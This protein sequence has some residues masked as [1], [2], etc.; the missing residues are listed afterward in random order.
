MGAAGTAQGAAA[1]FL[2]SPSLTGST[3]A[4][5]LLAISIA[6]ARRRLYF[7]NAYFVAHA[8]LVELL[9][10]AA[11]RGV[12]VRVLTNG[13]RSDVA[14]TWLAGR[15]RY[16]TLLAAGVRIYEY[17]P[18]TLHSKTFV[19]TASGPLSAQPTSIIARSP[20]TSKSH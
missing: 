10:S 19:Q 7:T 2:Y 15:S 11:R 8:D 12:D 5:R 17:E 1:A 20:T 9:A 3:A 6:S 16:E 4:E 13:P 14:T 18:A